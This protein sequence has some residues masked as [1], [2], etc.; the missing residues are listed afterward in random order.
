V[1]YNY[2]C[3]QNFTAKASSKETAKTSQQGR[4]IWHERDVT[5]RKDLLTLK[6]DQDGLLPNDLGG[7]S[8]VDSTKG[9]PSYSINPFKDEHSNAQSTPRCAKL[10]TNLTNAWTYLE[11]PSTNK[12]PL[13]TILRRLKRD[14]A[15][16]SLRLN[17]MQRIR[18]T[19]LYQL[20][21]VE[22]E[23]KVADG[24]PRD[25]AV[26]LVT[27]NLF[28]KFQEVE[29]DYQDTMSVND[30]VKHISGI[31]Q[32]GERWQ[33][34]IDACG[35]REILLIDEVITYDDVKIS[36]DQDEGTKRH[37]NIDSE[38]DSDVDSEDQ[39]EACLMEEDD[40]IQHGTDTKFKD[41]KRILLAP[42][43]CL[44]ATCQRLDGVLDMM[45]RCGFGDHSFLRLGGDVKI[46]NGDKHPLSN[47]LREFLDSEIQRRIEKVFG[48]PK[49]ISLSPFESPGNQ[50]SSDNGDQSLS[51]KI[52]GRETA[53]SEKK[54]SD[55]AETFSESNIFSGNGK[56]RCLY[57]NYHL[58]RKRRPK[59][60]GCL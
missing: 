22:L 19:G 54:D 15:I 38:V 35:C 24:I 40:I 20:Q 37:N 3:S 6:G 41:L 48:K 42:E 58:W 12:E 27:A 33:E 46:E 17:G 51:E 32:A 56:S 4:P 10:F 36:D 31:L 2:A 59:S 57:G 5:N 18:S 30:F 53:A 26:K 9:N 50:D 25:E 8:K 23:K 7:S 14:C 39:V 47:D 44:K 52:N 49:S 1:R 16:A 21:Q 34:L 28:A 13:L 55:V 11:E 45:E 43:L 29:F 60:K